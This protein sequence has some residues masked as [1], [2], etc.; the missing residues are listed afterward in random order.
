MKIIITGSEGFLGKRLV[1]S[2]EKNHTIFKYDISTGYD[3]LD[4]LQLEKSFKD[5]SPNVIIHLA[6]CADLNIFKQKPEIS[7]KVNV[8][9]TRNIL[10]LCETYNT[11]LL[12]AS[13]C[14]C[15]G[16][17]NCHPSNEESKLS[18][19]E[20]Y[21]KSKAESEKDILEVGLPHCCMRLATFY[22]PEMRSALAPAIFLDLSHKNKTIQIHGD[23]NQSRTMTYVDDIVSGIVTLCETEPKYT[24]V[25][26]TTEE[27]NTVLE[28]IQI[29]KVLTGNNN[30]CIHIND[31]YGQ[32]YTELIS[33]ERLR[34][35]GWKPKYTFL[36]GMKKS[37]EYYKLNNYTFN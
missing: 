8:I 25:N 29:S 9:G 19:T 13:T 12:F 3:I 35:L 20:P 36:E 31:R 5:F 26:I 18:P 2:L 37:Y 1:R 30:N 23:G 10:H 32:I 6:A 7:Y 16:N 24:V 14:C 27:V 4:T 17:N 22:G 11:R 15:Y 34:S 33:N 28:M 21:A